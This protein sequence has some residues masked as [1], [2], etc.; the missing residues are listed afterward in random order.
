MTETTGV[1]EQKIKI[2]QLKLAI[3]K[4]NK[5]YFVSDRM[6]DLTD[7]CLILYLDT[8]GRKNRLYKSSDVGRFITRVKK[9][10]GITKEVFASC[11]QAAVTINLSHHAKTTTD[12]KKYWWNKD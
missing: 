2:L 7:P 11:Y 8:E 10:V 12:P 5:A 9:S 3:Q 4:T 6:A 1:V